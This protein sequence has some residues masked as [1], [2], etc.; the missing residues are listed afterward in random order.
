MYIDAKNI[1]AAEQIVRGSVKAIR[2]LEAHEDR[3]RRNGQTVDA[4]AAADLIGTE[5]SRLYAMEAVLSA[6]GIY[7]TR[8]RG[9]EGKTSDVKL[10]WC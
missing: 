3:L 1:R 6:L 10:D 7:V 5:T 4:D 8:N 9:D 2:R